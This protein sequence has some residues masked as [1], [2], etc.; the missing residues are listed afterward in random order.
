MTMNPD[1][2]PTQDKAAFWS[3]IRAALQDDL[4][5]GRYAPGDRL[6]SE[7]ALAA[8]FAANRHTVRR[9]LAALAEAGLVHARQGAGV[10]VTAR[11]A[12]YHITRRTR[13]HRNM[14]APGQTLETRTLTTET[15]AADPRE[16]EALGIA[17]GAPLHVWEGLSFADGAPLALFRSAFCAQRFPDLL[18]VLEDRKSVTAAL[19][20]FGVNDY[21]RR[22]TRLSA[23]RA[24]SVLARHLRLSEGA[25]LLRTVSVN[26]DSQGQP[27]EYGRTWFA[28]DRVQ[29]I[30]E[31]E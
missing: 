16:A 24:D 31:P 5:S 28:G 10:Y 2:G 6:P 15:R 3:R 26:V 9:A 22:S 4:A 14:N 20:A 7:A 17:P 11:P 30:V 12:D 8:R 25:P 29:L 18:P 13:F 1:D 19:A 21:T 27:V 23:E